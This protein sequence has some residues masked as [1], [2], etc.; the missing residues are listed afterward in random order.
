VIGPHSNPARW[1]REKQ[2]AQACHRA[3]RRTNRVAD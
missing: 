2:A 3:E 1:D